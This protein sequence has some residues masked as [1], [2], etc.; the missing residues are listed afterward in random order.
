MIEK[1]WAI[2][3]KGVL[4]SSLPQDILLDLGLA[5]RPAMVTRALDL[6]AQRPDIADQVQA[7]VTLLI[8]VF[9]RLDRALLILSAPGAGKTTLLL[10]LARDLMIRAT[11]DP[12]HPIPVVFPLSTWAQ[13]RR[14]LVDWLVDALHEQYEVPRKTGQAWVDA[15]QFLPLLDELDEVKAEDRTACIEVINEFRQDHGL[16]SLVVCSRVADYEALATQLRLQGA[17]MVQL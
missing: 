1:V 14:P 8:D 16:L 15:E 6:Y 9:D 2:W 5:E 10:T 4:Q 12:N 17:L 3:I 7:S 11:Q 13:Q